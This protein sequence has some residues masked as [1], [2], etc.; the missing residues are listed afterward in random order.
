V[1]WHSAFVIGQSLQHC[2]TVNIAPHHG[3][4]EAE[5]TRP[6]ESSLVGWRGTRTPARIPILDDL[7]RYAIYVKTP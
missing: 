5:E 1:V 7:K 4:V 6:F 2:G 3:A